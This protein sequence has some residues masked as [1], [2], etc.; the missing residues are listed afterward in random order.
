MDDFNA[1]ATVE[2]LIRR[3]W[4]WND[5]KRLEWV[6]D[7]LQKKNLITEAERETLLELAQPPAIDPG[8]EKNSNINSGGTTGSAELG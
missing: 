8:P 7:A 1:F 3:G 4:F 6:L 2:R 5:I